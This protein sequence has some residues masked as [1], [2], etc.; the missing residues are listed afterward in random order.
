MANMV[1]IECVNNH[2]TIEVEMG[3][4]L[5]ELIELVGL[6]W[7]RQPLAALVNNKVKELNY[8][9]YTPA[10]VEFFDISHLAGFRV[11]QR[12]MIFIMHISVR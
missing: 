9:I 1:K 2:S 7:K 6:E 3:T 10:K 4:S 8:L 11:Y 12:S 5:L